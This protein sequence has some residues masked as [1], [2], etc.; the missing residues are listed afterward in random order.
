MRSRPLQHF[1]TSDFVRFLHE[2]VGMS[3]WGLAIHE[4]SRMIA[5]SSNLKEVTVFMPA[6]VEHDSFDNV[7]QVL[8]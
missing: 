2:N 7:I 5:V 4:K 6:L 1:M 3:A 8:E